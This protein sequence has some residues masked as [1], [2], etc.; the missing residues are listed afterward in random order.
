MADTVIL[1]SHTVRT[2]TG[3]YDTWS[4]IACERMNESE[5]ETKT[6]ESS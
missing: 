6:I 1:F 4:D 2:Y 3:T 5:I